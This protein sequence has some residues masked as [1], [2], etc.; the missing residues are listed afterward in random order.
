M[1]LDGSAIGI[2]ISSCY[3]LKAYQM[4]EKLFEWERI[5]SESA[6]YEDSLYDIWSR[7]FKTVLA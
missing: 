7:F 3:V 5:H 4:F 2:P 1:Q 6:F